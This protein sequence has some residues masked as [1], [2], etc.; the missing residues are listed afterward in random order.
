[1]GADDAVV[2]S[3]K[4]ARRSD[5]LRAPTLPDQPDGSA[6]AIFPVGTVLC[7]EHIRPTNAWRI[8]QAH[9]T[10]SSRTFWMLFLPDFGK[11]RGIGCAA[12]FESIVRQ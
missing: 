5:P 3:L 2:L 10:T 4:A 9:P 8:I 1:L 6:Q 11:G 12:P 7:A